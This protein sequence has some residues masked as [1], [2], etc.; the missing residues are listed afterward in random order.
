MK[1]QTRKR[2]TLNT[3]KG[4]RD[5]LP[6]QAIARRFVVEK[7]RSTFERFG[8]DPIETP[9]L[10]YAEVLTGKYGED[11]DK[12]LYT[13][14]D[15]GERMVGLR[16][17]QT[18]PTARLIGQYPELP[19]PFK[20]YQIQSVWR[21]EKPQSG[22]FREVLQCDA[23]IFAP[24]LTALM[25]AEPLAL[26]YFVLLELGFKEITIKVNSRTLLFKMME[27]AGVSR[28]LQLPA[29]TAIDKLDKIGEE[30]V[31]T[32]L[33]K[34]LSP[35]TAEAIFR[36]LSA[37]KPD[38]YLQICLETAYALGV[39]KE[40]LIF[41]PTLARGLDYYT[42]IIYEAVIAGYKPGSAA[43]GGHYDKLVGRFFNQ[44]MPGT[45]FSLGFDRLLEALEQ[46]NLLPKKVTVSDVLVTIFSPEF[47]QKSIDIAS[48]LRQRNLNV[49][50]Y[51]DASTKLDKQL[52]YADKKGIPYAIII[53]PDE[54]Q[55]N[56]VTLK[57]LQKQEQKQMT[58][59]EVINLLTPTLSRSPRGS[60]GFLRQLADSAATPEV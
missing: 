34:K 9:A 57:D 44:D 14:K 40:S 54:V 8:Y 35:Q 55:R 51:L 45:G 59:E 49:E 27:K 6:E 41:S 50:L 24:N 20:R 25:D 2:F 52:K 53:G 4:F 5:F 32:Q 12:L 7:I 10:E 13:F 28:S 56:V 43:G 33:A 3:L 26:C 48:L 15:R 29:I 38:D 36:E 19:K 60:H 42:G 16:Y 46:F 22:R 18:V 30:A 47:S 1:P 39:L 11:A 17:D 23:D 58:V 37:C 31:R 21:Q